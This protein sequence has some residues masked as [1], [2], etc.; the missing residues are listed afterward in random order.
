MLQAPIVYGQRFDTRA[1]F[2]FCDLQVNLTDCLGQRSLRILNPWYQVPI[3]VPKYGNYGSISHRFGAIDKRP[4][5]YVY[6]Q[7]QQHD[8]IMALCT[9]CEGTIKIAKI[10]RVQHNYFLLFYNCD[11]VPH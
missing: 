5:C 9:L 6:S 10:N 1:I 8:R 2:T 3:S 4:I 11:Q 7:Q